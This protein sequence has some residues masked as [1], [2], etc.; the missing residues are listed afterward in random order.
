VVIIGTSNGRDWAAICRERK[1]D[2]R[3]A[4]NNF[5]EV[6][7]NFLDFEGVIR[8]ARWCVDVRFSRTGLDYI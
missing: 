3:A 1:P 4:S 5:L 8:L 7:Y 2:P 6:G